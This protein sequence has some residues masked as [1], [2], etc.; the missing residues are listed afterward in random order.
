[1]DSMQ[2][3][4][5]KLFSVMN[6]MLNI[7]EEVTEGE[8]EIEDI[9]KD[10]SVRDIEKKT[11]GKVSECKNFGT[12]EADLNVGGIAGAMAI[13]L[14]FDQEEELDLGQFGF[15]VVFETRAIVSRSENYGNITGKKNNVGGI[16]GKMDLGYI[17]DCVGAGTAKSTDGNYVVNCRQCYKAHQQVIQNQD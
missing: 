12:V 1:M 5:D 8:I 17:H 11:E 4:N 3:V 6:S 10:V 13:E 14:K 2:S 9:V 15:N 7:V 16:A